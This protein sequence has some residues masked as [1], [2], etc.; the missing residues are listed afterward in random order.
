MLPSDEESLWEYLHR[1]DFE[2]WSARN[3]P[4]T[5]VIVLDQFEELFTLGERIPDLVDAFRNDLGDLAENRIPA[6]L[7]ARIENDE[8][9]G[10]SIQLA[11]AQLQVVDQPAGGLSSRPR[12]MVSAHSRAGTLTGAALPLRAA[13]STRCGTQTGCAPDDATSWRAGWWASS[14]ARTSIRAATPHRRTSIVRRSRM[15]GGRRTRAAQPVLPRAQRGTE[16]GA[17]RRSSTSSWS[18]T[19][20]TTP[21]PTTTRRACVTCQT[22]V[23]RF[24]ETELI[25]EKGFRN[26]YIREDAVPI[27]SHR[28]GTRPPD[29][30]TAGTA[31]GTL[32][33]ATD[34]TDPRRA[35]RRGTRT[36]R[37]AP[38]RR[39]KAAQGGGNGNRRAAWAS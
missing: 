9:C 20:N 38:R 1:N 3:Y 10:G 27:A 32:R 30:L 36:P 5:P 34:R 29:R 13:R 15:L 24:I 6:D 39:E 26:F 37:P 21:C 28:R 31:R 35:H 2:L 23:A 8:A 22:R 17:G 25:T 19:P 4:L 7:A 33:R 16:D 14:P 12:R 11:V 18:R